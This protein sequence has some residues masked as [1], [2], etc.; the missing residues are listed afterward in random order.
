[1]QHDWKLDIAVVVSTIA[2]SIAR[3]VIHVN[4]WCSRT[5]QDMQKVP[6]T[7]A[8]VFATVTQRSQG[9]S[10]SAKHGHDWPLVLFEKMISS[11]YAAA[12]VVCTVDALIIPLV[13]F[14]RRTRPSSLSDF[15]PS[16]TAGVA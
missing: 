1:M 11:L 8:L 7:V 3:D 14:F 4:F 10:T 12:A 9:I 16:D 15:Q 2:A 13:Q 5:A 6:L